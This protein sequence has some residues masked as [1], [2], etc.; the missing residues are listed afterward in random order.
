MGQHGEPAVLPLRRAERI[1]E[2]V[3]A[4]GVEEHLPLQSFLFAAE[5][6]DDLVALDQLVIVERLVVRLRR[7]ELDGRRR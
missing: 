1:L 5:P 7:G 3:G 4:V 6:L 2:R